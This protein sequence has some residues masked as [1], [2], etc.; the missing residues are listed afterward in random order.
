MSFTM[1][2]KNEIALLDFSYELN[3]VFL[4]AFVRNNGEKSLD[5]IVLTI[6]NPKIVRKIDQ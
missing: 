6:E 5:K 3:M 4:A 1:E 2:I